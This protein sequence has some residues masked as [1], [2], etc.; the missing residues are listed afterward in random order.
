[1]KRIFAI[2]LILITAFS[3]NDVKVGYLETQD[4]E[5]VPNEM[6][7]DRSTVPDFRVEENIPWITTQIQGVQG[8]LPIFY[9]V[10]NIAGQDAAS[11]NEL[12]STLK[13]RGD[14]TFE[15]PLNNTLKSGK[16]YLGLKIYNE[17]HVHYKDSVYSII[18]P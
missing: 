9:G 16:Y 10:G 11:V 7:L 4:A 6:T 12:K 17:D 2:L 3:C 5:Y 18:I 8:T 15:I 14:G 1:M 13:V